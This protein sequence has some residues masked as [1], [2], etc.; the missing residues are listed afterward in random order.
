MPQARRQPACHRP[1]G[2]ELHTAKFASRKIVSDESKSVRTGLK[3]WKLPQ[4]SIST[5]PERFD[6]Q[7]VSMASSKRTEKLLTFR[8]HSSE[9]LHHQVIA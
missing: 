9:L 7:R 3:H 1:V 6:G 4:D 5:I 2:M 8:R